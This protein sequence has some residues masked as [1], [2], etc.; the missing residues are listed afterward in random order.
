MLAPFTFPQDLQIRPATFG[1]LNGVYRLKVA[2]GEADIT[3]EVISSHWQ[4]L[5]LQT[6]TCVAIATS[7]EIVGYA[8]LRKI[9]GLLF[10]PRVWVRTDWQRQGIGTGLLY[11]LEEQMRQLN[12]QDPIRLLAQ[13]W[14]QQVI[15]RSLLEKAGYHRTSAFQRMELR[16]NQPPVLV[17]PVPGIVIEQFVPGRD[18]QAVYVADEEAFLDERGKAPRTF[19]QWSQRLN[20]HT[21]HFDPSLWLIARDQGT[22]AGYALNDITADSGEI[23]HLGVRRPWRGRGLGSTLLL[24]ALDA[25]YQHGIQTVRLNVDTESLTGAQLLYQRHGFRTLDVYTNYIRTI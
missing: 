1:D 4:V 14:G 11:V 19:E 9:F 25:F 16:L 6:Q 10:A 15:E 12:R 23:M 2:A 13:V 21:A 5:D 18:E 24:C 22:I 7:N 3:T 20:M 17:A 8:E